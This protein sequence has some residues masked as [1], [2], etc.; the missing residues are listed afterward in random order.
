MGGAQPL[1]VTLNGGVAICVEVDPERIQRRLDHRYLDVRADDV[2]HALHLA[3]EAK[4]AKRALSIGLLGN[5]AEVVPALAARDFQVDVVTDQTPAHDPL[6]YVPAGLSPEDAAE[7][8]LDDPATYVRRAR[9]SMA[10]HVDAMVAFADRG[11]EVFDYGNSLRA[12]GRLGGSARAFDFPGFVLAFIRRPL[13][14]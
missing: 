13:C 4:N 12:E 14:H 10:R 8:R 7:L 3:L 9:E 2:E 11:S 6:S 1:A 5:A